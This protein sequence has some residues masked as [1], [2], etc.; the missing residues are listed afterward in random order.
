MAPNFEDWPTIVVAQRKSPLIYLFRS[1]SYPRA[2]VSSHCPFLCRPWSLVTSGSGGFLGLYLARQVAVVLVLRG[3]GGNSPE[4]VANE[5][6]MNPIIVIK[7]FSMFENTIYRTVTSRYGQ[8][9]ISTTNSQFRGLHSRKTFLTWGL[10]DG[11]RI[12]WAR[13]SISCWVQLKRWTSSSLKK[14][15]ELGLDYLGEAWAYLYT[16]LSR[17]LVY[18]PNLS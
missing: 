17:C 1:Y 10:K 4:V 14:A 2:A 9:P 11:H 7:D 3:I 5:M 13:H 8:S 16:S 12:W 18:Q 6:I 15:P